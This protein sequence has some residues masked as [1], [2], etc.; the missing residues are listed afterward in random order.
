MK[1]SEQRFSSGSARVACRMANF[2]RKG[3][4]SDVMNDVVEEHGLVDDESVFE[5]WRELI[6]SVRGS[7]RISSLDIQNKF[8]SIVMR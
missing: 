8:N 1:F 2:P 6:E 4:S 3:N 5:E 7:S